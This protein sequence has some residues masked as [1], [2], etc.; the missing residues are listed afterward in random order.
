M[1]I[2]LHILSAVSSIILTS[3]LIFKPNRRGTRFSYGLVGSTVATG[4]MLIVFAGANILS[5]CISGL[6]YLTVV[7]IGLVIVNRR[8]AVNEN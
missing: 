4:F 6:L 2:V 3:Y 7:A 8:L 5:T 1:L